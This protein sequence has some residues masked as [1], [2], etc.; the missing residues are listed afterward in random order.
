MEPPFVGVF[1][2]EVAHVAAAV[3]LGVAIKNLGVVAGLGDA[4]SVVTVG[5]GGEV[6]HHYDEVV[7]VFVPA[8]EGD[9]AVLVVV[10]VNPF[11]AVVG[12]VLAI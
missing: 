12:E 7:V 3:F 1:A 6:T 11:K 10:A 2:A 9:D 5:L 4:D 8:D